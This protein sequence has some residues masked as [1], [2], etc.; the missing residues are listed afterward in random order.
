MTQPMKLLQILWAHD[1]YSYYKN[2]DSPD[3]TFVYITLIV[4]ECEYNIN[5]I[6][7]PSEETR[8]VVQSSDETYML[9]NITTQTF[10]HFPECNYPYSWYYISLID[11]ND[12]IA[13]T[14]TSAKEMLSC[15]L[16]DYRVC[17]IMI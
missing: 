16:T 1:G 12:G 4:H 3:G 17:T 2:P 8:L 11:G 5:V 15:A 7:E 14:A 13:S 6:K 10:E 9:Y